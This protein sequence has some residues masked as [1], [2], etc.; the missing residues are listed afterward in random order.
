MGNRKFD[1]ANLMGTSKENIVSEPVLLHIDNETDSQPPLKKV[2]P[3]A[4]LEVPT[5]AVNRKPKKIIDACD[6][7]ERE[8]TNFFCRVEHVAYLRLLASYRRTGPGA[9]LDDALYRYF[10]DAEIVSELK[11]AFEDEQ[12]KREQERLS[13]ESRF[14][15]QES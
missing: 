15:I 3:D 1:F 4:S 13:L 12:K 5:Q 14:K 10:S 2:V 7:P 11:K 9:V 6:K 8:K